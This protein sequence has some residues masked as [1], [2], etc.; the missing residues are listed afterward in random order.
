VTRAAWTLALLL[1]SCTRA[2]GHGAITLGRYE[3]G[4]DEALFGRVVDGVRA[5]GYE[6][7]LASF[8]RGTIPVVARHQPR[9]GGGAMLVVQ[10]FREGWIVVDP[11]AP[12][13]AGPRSHGE[14]AHEAEVLAARVRAHLEGGGP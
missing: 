9:R 10:I 5:A 6:P 12:A 14:I 11:Q 13:E 1:A 8:E 3:A 2:T 7:G 4:S